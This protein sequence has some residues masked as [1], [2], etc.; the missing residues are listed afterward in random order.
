[1]KKTAVAAIE[2]TEEFFRSLHMPTCL[3]DMKMG[4]QPDEVLK[5]MAGK[6]DCR[7]DTMRKWALSRK[8]GQKSY[9]RFI[10][11]QTTDNLNI[12]WHAFYR[13]VFA[14]IIQWRSRI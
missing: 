13:N 2:R 9:M 6:G 12:D 5:E 7:G 1:M 3:G 4:V 10:K 14:L 11:G 8:W